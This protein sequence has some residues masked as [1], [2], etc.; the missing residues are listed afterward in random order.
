MILLSGQCLFISAPCTSRT[1]YRRSLSVSVL[2]FHFVSGKSHLP[3]FLPSPILP[4]TSSL[5]LFLYFLI[6]LPLLHFF[7][8]NPSIPSVILF[9]LH[10][11]L[12]RSSVSFPSY[13]VLSFPCFSVTLLQLLPEALFVVWPLAPCSTV[14][15]LLTAFVTAR[16]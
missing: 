14:V 6:R 5:S 16:S 7:L 2:V 12:F 15:Q 4:S 3:L 13:P 8:P 1:W 9:F 10:F 11:F